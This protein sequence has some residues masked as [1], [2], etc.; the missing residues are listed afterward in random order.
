MTGPNRSRRQ[1]DAL[2]R[3]YLYWIVS[4]V[5]L[6]LLVLVPVLLLNGQMRRQERRLEARIVA[7][8]ARLDPGSGSVSS[9][10]SSTTRAVSGPSASKRV[11][12]T[13]PTTPTRTSGEVDESRST[14]GRALMQDLR[15][16]LQET[17]FEPLAL[18]QP[19]LAERALQQVRSAGPDNLKLDAQTWVLLAIAALELEQEFAADDYARRAAADGAALTAYYRAF[20][21]RMVAAGRTVEAEPYIQRL[22]EQD[23]LRAEATLLDARRLIDQHD[24]A[25]ADELIETLDLGTLLL[26]DRLRLGKLMVRLERWDWLEALLGT[27]PAGPGTLAPARDFLQAVLYVAKGQT[28]EGSAILDLLGADADRLSAALG[29][30]DRYDRTLWQGVA[31]VSERQFEAARTLLDSAAR[32]DSARP[33]A[34]YWLGVIEMQRGKPEEAGRELTRALAAMADYAPAWELLSTITYAQDNYAEALAHAQRAVDG[35]ARRPSAHFLVAL[36][37]AQLDEIDLA[38]RTLREAI[39]LDPSYYDTARDAEVLV[40][41]LAPE[42]WAELEQWIRHQNIE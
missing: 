24:A 41:R 16:A 36:A 13:Q 35:N 31:K 29:F 9:R 3:L 20:A 30:P 12:S 10:P 4:T 6:A 8:E 39:A 23:G 28:T 26:S 33:Y 37:A 21:R 5:L 17:E 27:V 19:E 32:L 15:A 2:E 40:E 14:V 1:S 18:V 11:P 25:A 22:L 38:R 34:R 42:V 7:L